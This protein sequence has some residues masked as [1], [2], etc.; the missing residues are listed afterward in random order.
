MRTTTTRLALALLLLAPAAAAQS[1]GPTRGHAQADKLA[2]KLGLSDA[3]REQIR[4]SVARHAGGLEQRRAEVADAR[5]ELRRVLD[6]TPADAAAVRAASQRLQA[7][8][9]ERDVAR[10]ARWA[11][12]R[13]ALTPDQQGRA[14]QLRDE[15]RAQRAEKK[16]ARA[17][18]RAERH[19]RRASGGDAPR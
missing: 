12:V 11:D 4:G 6:A 17:E 8:R 5:A 13:A 10:G 9:T 3:Q 7:V 19:A 18:R 14:Q 15:R 16:A 1:A 2:R